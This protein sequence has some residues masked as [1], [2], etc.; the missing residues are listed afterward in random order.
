MTRQ[1][2]RRSA[3]LHRVC[4]PS[5]G[6][7]R[8]RARVDCRALRQGD[9]A[10]PMGTRPANHFDAED[11]V[12]TVT[13]NGVAHRTLPEMWEDV[14]SFFKANDVGEALTKV[15]PHEYPFIPFRALQEAHV[16]KLYWKADPDL[17]GRYA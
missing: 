5:D 17:P 1:L 15:V 16:N 11:P 8:R 2:P 3:L 10:Q 14:F 12:Q 13:Y 7:P 9:D 6:P 4:Y